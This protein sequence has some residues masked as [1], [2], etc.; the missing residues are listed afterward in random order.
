M[1][2][3]LDLLL[4]A[5]YPKIALK[6][7]PEG[8]ALGTFWDLDGVGCSRDIVD[9]ILATGK[10]PAY[11]CQAQWKD[12]HDYND[13]DIRIVLKRAREFNLLVEKYPNVEF[14]F[15]PWCEHRANKALITK[16]VNQ[17]KRVLNPRV[18]I[19]NAGEGDIKN[20]LK[21][22]HH[23]LG[24]CDIFSFD[25]EGFSASK[26]K[27]YKK[28]HKNCKY[29]FAWDWPFN[30]RKDENDKTPRPERKHKPTVQEIKEI[31]NLIK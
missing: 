1:I 25:G 15:S 28:A 16:C 4:A 24:A 2:L 21:E 5:K 17:L 3:G 11:R 6:A 20:T 22:R 30:C 12:G 14:L 27:A 29:F 7:F 26:A 13:G 18:K 10:C 8:F 23:D 19:V 9:T 31:A